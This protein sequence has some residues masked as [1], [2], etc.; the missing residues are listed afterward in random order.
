MKDPI[1]Q[2][3]WQRFEVPDV[4][5]RIKPSGDEMANT[6]MA[7]WRMEPETRH[8]LVSFPTQRLSS[9]ASSDKF[10]I[11]E[12]AKTLVLGTHVRRMLTAVVKLVIVSSGRRSLREGLTASI[13]TIALLHAPHVLPLWQAYLHLRILL[14]VNEQVFLATN[15][16]TRA[17]ML[18]C[19]PKAT[20]YSAKTCSAE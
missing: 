12:H 17:A 16:P 20:A 3:W 1:L 8:T 5:S 18:Q 13:D 14:R 9:V 4:V 10:L 19:F 7:D 11:V 15:A 2:R 6:K